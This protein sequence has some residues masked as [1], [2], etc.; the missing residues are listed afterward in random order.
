MSKAARQRTAR[1]RLA[2]QRAREAARQKRLRGIMIS[3][4]AV[5]VLVVA[6]V[7][8]VVVAN[9]KSGS[10]PSDYAGP[11][12]P[13]TK[14]ADG[15][16]L[17]AQPN[18]AAPTLNLYEDLQC[19][20]CKAFEAANGA[21]VE[22]LAYQGKV[23]VVYHLLGFVNPTGSIRAAV[24]A[25]CAADAGKFVEFHNVAY[26][27]QPAETDALSITKLKDFGKQAGISGGD[28]DKC[29]AAQAGASQAQTLTKAGLDFLQKQAGPNGQA[30][31]PALFLNG[32]AV[33]GNPIMT[34]GGLKPIILAA[35]PAPPTAP[36]AAPSASGSSQPSVSATPSK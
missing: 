13:V 29:V 11:F 19:P 20:V 28:F 34:K 32:Q 30:G 14:Q 5:V 3:V 25:G 26:K 22:Q 18:A 24:A 6:V 8:G 7:I 33:T 9:G 15:T 2:E 4:S 10:G 23:K 1:E 12:A 27:K 16:Y 31:T 21:S 17:M 36:L 35:A